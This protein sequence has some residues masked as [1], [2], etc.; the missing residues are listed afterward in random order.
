MEKSDCKNWFIDYFHLFEATPVFILVLLFFW[1]L[2]VPL[3]LPIPFVF[4]VLL[5]FYCITYIFFTIYPFFI[6]KKTINL[7]EKFPEKGSE[8]PHHAI[9]IAHKKDLVSGEYNDGDYLSGVDILI[10]KFQNYS[11]RYVNYK[12]YEVNT[13]KQV[14]S[15]ILDE[16]T[17]HLWIF[18]HGQRNKLRLK[19]ES[20]CYFEVRNSP[21]KIFIGQY[22][23]NSVFGTSLADYNK[24]N[25]QD[26]THWLRMDPFIRFSVSKKL[27]ELEL[28]NL[29]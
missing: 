25:A 18:G 19:G 20:L 8:N 29:L 9:I 4:L 28:N 11:E 23:C 12:I 3:H 24:P 22:H 16:K 6:H 10:E 1:I 7:I 17:T 27:K 14:I 13:K 15:I 21:K 2:L 26:V 5:V